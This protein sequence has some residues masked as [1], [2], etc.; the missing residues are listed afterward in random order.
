MSI[1]FA[2]YFPQFFFIPITMSAISFLSYEPYL[3]EQTPVPFSILTL[4]LL[5]VICILVKN[6][7]TNLYADEVM[8][9]TDIG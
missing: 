5:I 1:V 2:F 8:N 7:I 4:G 3:F 6:A 9:R